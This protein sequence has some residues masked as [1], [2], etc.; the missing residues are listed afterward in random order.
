[1]IG[2]GWLVENAKAKCRVLVIGLDAAE[3]SLLRRWAGAGLLPAI[4]RAIASGATRPLK[5]EPGLYA[6]SVWPSIFT[7]RSAGAHG[8]YNFLK[9]APG[10]YAEERFTP[11]MLAVEPFWMRLSRAG[12]RST[13]LD[14]PKM[15]LPDRFAGM[16][17]S[18]WGT[19][20]PERP[21][22]VLPADLAAEVAEVAGV[23]PVGSC[24]RFECR[25]PARDELA[26][27]LCER[28]RRRT[29][30]ALHLLAKAPADLVFV[31]YTETHC[32]GHHLWAA[33]ARAGAAGRGDDPLANPY[34]RML[35]AIDAG[36]G[37]L[38]ATVGDRTPLLIL[39]SHGMGDHND[40]THL[41][42]RAL[43]HLDGRGARRGALRLAAGALFRAHRH[44]PPGLADPLRPALMRL[45]ARAQARDRAGRR[46]FQ[47][48]TNDNAAGVRVN[49]E[50]REPH[51]LVEPGPEFD[52]TLRLLRDRLLELENPTSGAPA[53]RAV[54]ETRAA[55]AGGRVGEL[56]DLVLLWNR[57][58]PFEALSAPWLGLVR[59]R[60]R[61]R[62]VGDHRGEGMLIA[63]APGLVDDGTR[64]ALTAMSVA[65]TI[66]AALGLPADG[67]EDA[68]FMPFVRAVRLA[69]PNPREAAAAVADAV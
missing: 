4:A 65:P 42:D 59:G 47:V 63:A 18:D 36:I 48:A 5:L 9:L 32:G 56:P 3:P 64:P 45:I 51:G 50:G 15:P 57:D 46:W 14:I 17:V 33:H 11:A 62:R 52:R 24:D 41:V 26:A 19:H 54:L 58:H 67:F 55:F 34:L 6:G 39:S 20:D 7:G 1:M 28:V 37:R 53:F 29:D 68:A 31:T 12:L 60:Y 61:G 35:Q 27:A 21:M 8:R 30:L 2:T 22:T 13:L 66:T 49:L 69:E 44:L 23:D 43:R 38:R 40:G 10:S 16:L 25:S